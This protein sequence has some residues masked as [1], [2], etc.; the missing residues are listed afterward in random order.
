MNMESEQQ[1]QMKM[2]FLKGPQ[3]KSC[4]CLPQWERSALT[5]SVLRCESAKVIVWLSLVPQMAYISEKLFGLKLLFSEGRGLRTLL[6]SWL[7][8]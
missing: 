6:L 5:K 4:P 3:K 1:I 2:F 8:P 7:P